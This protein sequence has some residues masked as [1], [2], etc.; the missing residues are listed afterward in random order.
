MSNKR[1]SFH[2]RYSYSSSQIC[3]KMK[4]IS[5]FQNPRQDRPSVL[6]GTPDL[7]F[8]TKTVICCRPVAIRARQER[9]VLGKRAADHSQGH[10]IQSLTLC[11]GWPQENPTKVYK[12]PKQPKANQASADKTSAL[13]LTETHALIRVSHTRTI[14]L[15]FKVS[16]FTFRRDPSSLISMAYNTAKADAGL[17]NATIIAQE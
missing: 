7:G 17:Q 11:P 3:Y 5:M 4:G 10:N 15:M 6:L 16:S 9:S 8:T 2:Y 13:A 14:D 1:N 12:P